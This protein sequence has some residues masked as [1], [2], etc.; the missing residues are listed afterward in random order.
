MVRTLRKAKRSREVG[1]A[2]DLGHCIWKRPFWA[3]LIMLA[4]GLWASLHE[5]PLP[6]HLLARLREERGRRWGCSTVVGILPARGPVGPRHAPM[7]RAPMQRAPVASIWTHCW[8]VLGL[9]VVLRAGSDLGPPAHLG[10]GWHWWG[11]HAGKGTCPWPE[12]G[13]RSRQKLSWSL[14]AV[15]SVC[16]RHR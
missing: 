8:N 7:Q 12:L 14:A 16:V 4:Q 11:Q 10:P 5:P 15:L 6:W 9:S 2:R 13:Q 3:G 1:H